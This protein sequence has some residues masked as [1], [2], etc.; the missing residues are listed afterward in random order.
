MNSKEASNV[1]EAALNKVLSEMPDYE[2]GDLLVEWVLIAYVANPDDEKNSAY[3]MLFSNGEMPTY[4]ARGLL[5]TGLM[6]LE[7]PSE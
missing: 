6:S 1:V 4:R 2:E 7:V 3:P 5:Q